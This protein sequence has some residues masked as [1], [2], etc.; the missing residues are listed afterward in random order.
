MTKDIEWLEETRKLTELKPLEKNPRR[1]SKQEFDRLVDKIKRLGYSN[2]IKINTDNSVVG[3]HQRI[4][5]LKQLGHQEV[6]VLV[7]TRLLTEK[8]YRESV[9]TDNLS[10]G[11]HDFDILANEW[12]VP[13]LIDFGMMP[14]WFV[15]DEVEEI[16]SAEESIAEPDTKKAAT[17]VLGDRWLLGKHRLMCGD[18]TSITD[19]E[20]LMNGKKPNMIYTDPPYGIDLEFGENYAKC[21]TV[22]KK[23]TIYEKIEGDTSI[24]IA[25]DVYNLLISLYDCSLV[26][27]GANYYDF[28]PASKCWLAWDKRGEM[29]ENTFCGAELAY[30]NS[31]KHTAVLKVLWNGMYREGE[32]NANPRVH[33][34][35]K[36]IKLAI[37]C[38]DYLEA[39]KV[40]LDT[41]GGSGTTLMACEQSN[42]QCYMMEVSPHYCDVIVAR[43]EKL[44]GEKAVLEIS[45]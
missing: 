22:A 10:A 23:R 33:P 13:E 1:I 27:W 19:L 21:T 2:R 36:P 3:G 29:K 37:D 44:T 34:T 20:K 43:W 18:S 41:F 25:K 31:N 30:T 24:D 14:E 11:E 4:R 17:T 42:R 15:G 7:P 32:S 9:I 8:E 39:G 35:Q 6:K 26:Y 5:A 45:A 16:E 12:D 38:F 28:L 40:V